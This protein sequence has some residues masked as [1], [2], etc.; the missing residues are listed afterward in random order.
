MNP[1]SP[2][3]QDVLQR[4][5]VLGERHAVHVRDDHYDP[6]LMGGSANTTFMVGN[7]VLNCIRTKLEF[8][9]AIKLDGAKRFFSVL[10]LWADRHHLKKHEDI[11]NDPARPD[12]LDLID[13]F[14]NSFDVIRAFLSDPEKEVERSRH[15]KWAD[16]V[17][18]EGLGV[19]DTKL[20]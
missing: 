11:V 20:D 6:M 19:R 5:D 15:Q 12:G 18:R 17:I 7:V 16:Q 2:L 8:T 4:L 13:W 1:I 3:A 10:L 14:V 9:A